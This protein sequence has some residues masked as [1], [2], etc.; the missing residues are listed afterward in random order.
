MKVRWGLYMG[1]RRRNNEEKRK[2]KQGNTPAEALDWCPHRRS[3]GVG[4]ITYENWV[5]REGKKDEK[6]QWANEEERKLE[7]AKK[8][9]ELAGGYRK[10]PSLSLG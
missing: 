3:F 4:R 2:T 10:S 8:A 9:N 7:R 6:N 1:C 5:E